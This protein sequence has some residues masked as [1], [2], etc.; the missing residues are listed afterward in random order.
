[1][2]DFDVS[3]AFYRIEYELIDSMIRNLK[4]H[5]AEEDEKGLNWEQWQVLQLQELERYRKENP[6]KFGAEFVEIEERIESILRTAYN[7]A[8][9][10]EEAN[11]LKRLVGRGKYRKPKDKGFFSLNIGKLEHLILATKADFA[12]G[13]W[14]LLRRANDI[15]KRV[16]FDAQMYASAG[17]T[18]EQAVDMA[19]KDFLRAGIQSITYRNGARHTIQ[20]YASM[21]IRTGQQRAYLMGEGDLHDQYGLHTVRVNQRTNACPLCVRWLGKVLVDDVYS[22]GTYEEAKALNVPTLSQAMAMGFLHPNCKDTYS[23]YIEGVSKPAEPWTEAEL[24]EVADNYN[25][26]QALKHANGMAKSYERM[27]KWSLDEENRNKYK[28]RADYWKNRAKE[29]ELKP[30]YDELLDVLDRYEKQLASV[31]D[32]RECLKKLSPSERKVWEEAINGGI[33]FTGRESYSPYFDFVYLRN[34]STARTTFHELGHR[35]DYTHKTIEV[36]GDDGN[37]YYVSPSAVIDATADAGQIY[38]EI[39]DYFGYEVNNRGNIIGDRNARTAE[40]KAS[41]HKNKLA[42]ITKFKDIVQ[43][44]NGGGFGAVI[45]DCIEGITEGVVDEYKFAGGHRKSYWK[46]DAFWGTPEAETLA[47][48]TGTNATVEAFANYCSLKAL[49]RDDVIA[50]LEKISPTLVEE[51]EYAYG[52][53]FY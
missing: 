32:V 34:D 16:I 11:I 27:A 43:K 25:A 49:G 47:K 33:M 38:Q 22:G 14:S 31:E 18:Y 3:K 15:Y 13:E 12:K 26:E 19:T 48:G 51:L 17:G 24:Q 2:K 40:Q 9:T 50:E 44:V 53:I 46:D 23:V 37:T 10:K 35:I 20:D 52:Q 8:R 28:A 7:D 1:M 39:V 21:A 4:R 42:F 6:E 45:V 30:K 36:E 29:I 41:A 5:R